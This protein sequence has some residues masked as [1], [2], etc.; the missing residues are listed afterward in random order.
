MLEII[1]SKKAEQ[2]LIGIWS[3]TF[4]KWDE[5]QADHY[6]DRLNEGF[7]LIAANPKITYLRQEFENPVYIYPYEHQLIVYIVN[8]KAIN[9]I[10]VL[11]KTMN[12]ELQLD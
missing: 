2:D 11:H 7:D 10:R 4:N 9:I 8:D 6:L 12:V 5:A 3:Y 1:T